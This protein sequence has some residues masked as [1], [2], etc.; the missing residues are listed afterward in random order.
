MHR[1]LALVVVVAALL[2][3][4]EYGFAT[5]P[6]VVMGCIMMRVCHLDTC[7]VGIATQ[8]PKLREKFAAT[9]D[10]SAGEGTEVSGPIEALVMLLAGRSAT[11]GRLT[12]ISA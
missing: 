6:L 1:W 5:A 8:N 3:A 7:P 11:I 9:A 12:G 2:G 4:E 10:W